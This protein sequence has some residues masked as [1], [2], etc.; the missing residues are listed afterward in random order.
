M[1]LLRSARTLLAKVNLSLKDFA[2][3]LGMKPGTAM[4]QLTTLLQGKGRVHTLLKVANCLGLSPCELLLHLS[5]GFPAYHPDLSEDELLR[6][7]QGI[8]KDYGPEFAL[9]Y[10]EELEARNRLSEEAKLKALRL[11]WSATS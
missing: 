8:L 11:L 6:I 1:P 10:L 5:E 7:L 2:S 9:A 3:C 4:H